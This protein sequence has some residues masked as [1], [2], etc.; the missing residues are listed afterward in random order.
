MGSLVP[1]SKARE[2]DMGRKRQR[3]RGRQISRVEER[4]GKGESKMSVLY[5]KEALRERKAGMASSG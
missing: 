1:R 4:K 2:V 5:R 3:G